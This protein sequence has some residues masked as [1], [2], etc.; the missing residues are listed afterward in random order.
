MSDKPETNF[1]YLTRKFGVLTAITA[2]ITGKQP[3]LTWIEAE[4][5]AISEEGLARLKTVGRI[6]AQ[7]VAP[8]DPSL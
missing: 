4:V 5:A 8:A 6:P 3:P 1:A 2:A 7:K